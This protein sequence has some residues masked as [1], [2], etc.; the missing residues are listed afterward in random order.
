[1]TLVRCPL[2]E[3]PWRLEWDFEVMLVCLSVHG[4][5]RVASN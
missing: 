1:M 2:P 4:G 3:C 5:W